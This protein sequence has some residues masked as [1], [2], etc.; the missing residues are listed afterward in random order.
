MK[1]KMT[2]DTLDNKSKCYFKIDG[3]LIHKLIL[4]LPPWI[5]IWVNLFNLDGDVSDVEW[6]DYFVEFITP[7]MACDP[8]GDFLLA[9]ADLTACI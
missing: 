3:W 6:K 4:Y 9:A 7:F 2:E 8:D 5:Q 1:D